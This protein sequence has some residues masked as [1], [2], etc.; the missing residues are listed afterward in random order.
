MIGA[1]VSRRLKAGG[2]LVAGIDTREVDCDL[3]LTADVSDRRDMIDAAEHV[4]RGLG[5]V[6]LL[7][8][9]ANRHEAARLGELERTRWQTML[10]VNLG[11]TVNACAAVVPSMVKAGR[12]TVV[13]TTSW[14]SLA[15]A[16]GDPYYAA[17]LGA[18]IAF[19]KSFSMEVVKDGVRVNCVAVGPTEDESPAAVGGINPASLP[20]ACVTSPDDVASTVLFLADEGDYYVGQVFSPIAGVVF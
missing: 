2:W 8:T 1:R 18:V 5:P 14:R 6:D 4:R 11:G 7:V 20:V 13:T 10:K 12:G 17:S 9:T 3:S 16:A 15:G 19:T